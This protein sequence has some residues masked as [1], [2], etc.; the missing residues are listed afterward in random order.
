MDF[1]IRGRFFCFWRR[2]N[3]TASTKDN[4]F[5]LFNEMKENIKNY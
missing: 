3:S 1:I 2:L 4:Q 5:A